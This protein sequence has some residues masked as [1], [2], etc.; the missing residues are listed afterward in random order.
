MKFFSPTFLNF[1]GNLNN[2][3]L[4]TGLGMLILNIFSKYIELNLSKT[5]EQYIKSAI[6]REVLIFTI[7]FIGTHDILL[8]ILLTAAFITLSNTVF[9][10]D[11]RFCLMS[12]KYKALNSV[13]DTNKDGYVSDKEIKEARD[14]LEKAN[15][16]KNKQTKIDGSN[17]F[18]TNI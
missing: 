12:K 17:Y 9:H 5:Q 18:Q 10:E 6:G 16:Q 14:I 2:S 1:Y 3:K 15:I 7:V 4:L 11:S 8:S 13:L